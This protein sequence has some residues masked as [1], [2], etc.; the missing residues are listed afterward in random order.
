MTPD[1]IRQLTFVPTEN[2]K[3]ENALVVIAGELTAQVAELNR[4]LVHIG[5]T[6]NSILERTLEID[7]LAMATAAADPETIREIS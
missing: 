6:L 3:A 1:Q 2:L 7:A 5:F 4:N